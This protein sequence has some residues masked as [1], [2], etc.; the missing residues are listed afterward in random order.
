MMASSSPLLPI[1]V[2]GGDDSAGFN[3]YNNSLM[4]GVRQTNSPKSKQFLKFFQSYEIAQPGVFSWPLVAFNAVS[5]L[6]PVM[7]LLLNAL[8]VL[9]TVGDKS[10]LCMLYHEN[11]VIKFVKILSENL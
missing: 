9:V 2:Y 10:I 1:I 11:S 4:A 6:V 5:A 7:G 3:T 8:L